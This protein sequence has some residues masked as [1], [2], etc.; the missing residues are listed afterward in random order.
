M[1]DLLIVCSRSGVIESVTPALALLSGMAPAPTPAACLRDAT[2]SRQ[3]QRDSRFAD[4]SPSS[5]GNID[6]N[7]SLVAA[8]GFGFSGKIRGMKSLLKAPLVFHPANPVHPA[9]SA[10]AAAVERIDVEVFVGADGRVGL[11]FSVRAPMGCLRVPAP[12]AS[13]F[14]DGLWRHTCGELFVARAGAAGYREYNFSPSGEWAA[15]SFA[16]Y[17]TPQVAGAADAACSAVAPEISVK[18]GDAGFFMCV[19]LPPG[20]IELDPPALDAPLQLAVTMVLEAS[21]GHLSYWA[22]THPCA[23]PDFHHRDGFRQIDTQRDRAA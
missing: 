6:V 2:D 1:S 10:A 8:A 4:F 5:R 9:H 17:R 15:Y 16:D 7:L 20:T 13:V 12:S 14:T 22:L 18:Q 3:R 23:Q 21:D 19:D 11:L